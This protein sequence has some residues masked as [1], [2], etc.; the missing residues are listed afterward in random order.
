MTD[1][2]HNKQKFLNNDSRQVPGTAN[3]HGGYMR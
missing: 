1:I 3:T 2:H